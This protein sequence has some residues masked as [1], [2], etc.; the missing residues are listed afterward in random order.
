M[1]LRETSLF[2]ILIK[3]LDLAQPEDENPTFRVVFSLICEKINK[4]EKALK[5][6]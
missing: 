1:F 3:I 6:F 2:D 4:L 5:A